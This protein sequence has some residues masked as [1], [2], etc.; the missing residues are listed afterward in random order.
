MFQYS[1]DQLDE[2]VLSTRY[3][4]TTRRRRRS[5]RP[6]LRERSRM[7]R[8]SPVSVTH[9]S[10]LQVPLRALHLPNSV[11]LQSCGISESILALVPQS[12]SSNANL[13]RVEIR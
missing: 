12:R 13:V 10:H 2:V 9:S 6:G 11:L 7:G 8:A 1:S 4:T 3:Q 5:L